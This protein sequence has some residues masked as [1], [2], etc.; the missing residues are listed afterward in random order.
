MAKGIG[1][2]IYSLLSND[3]NVSA[4]VSNKIFPYMAIE[5]IKYPYIVY[6]QTGLEPTDTKDGVSP[7]DIEEW[8]VEMYAETLSEIEDLSDKVRAVL[9]RYSGTTETI[10]VQSVK[11]VSENGGY[12]DEDR[13]FLKMQAYSFR[14]MKC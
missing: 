1:D 7:L 6:E 14:V 13:V 12:A 10:V 11:F 4:I 5:S 2:V 3:A 9:D 8:D